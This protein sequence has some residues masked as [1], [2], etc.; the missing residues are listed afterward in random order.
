MYKKRK[1][2]YRILKWYINNK[3]MQSKLENKVIYDFG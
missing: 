3:I 1:E 2:K